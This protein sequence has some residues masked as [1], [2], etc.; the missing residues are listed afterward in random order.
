MKKLLL[1]LV[2]VFSLSL[3]G[4]DSRN[5]LEKAWDAMEEAD[6]YTMEMTMTVTGFGELTLEMYFD[7]D[8]IRATNPFGPDSYS[9]IVDGKE[10][11]YELVGGEYVLSDTPIDDEDESDMFDELKVEDFVQDGDKWVYEDKQYLSDD[12]TEYMEDITITLTDDGL[13]DTIT[14]TMISPELEAEVVVKVTDIN[15][16]KVELPSN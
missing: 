4:C 2:L 5:D 11:E 3:A 6:S 9:K 12:E 13:I 15:D 10:Y 14:F 8:L 7:D 1:A 16:T